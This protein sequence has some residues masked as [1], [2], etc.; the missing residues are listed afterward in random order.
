MSD[1]PINSLDNSEWDF[2]EIPEE[3]RWIAEIYEYSRENP[4][5]VSS[6]S[7]WL[8][9]DAYYID[10]W[11][12]DQFDGPLHEECVNLGMTVRKA[13]SQ[14]ATHSQEKVNEGS[15]YDWT[16]EDLVDVLN[17]PLDEHRLIKITEVLIEWPS[18]FVI[19]R[20]NE[21]VQAAISRLLDVKSL[22]R[23]DDDR[24]DRCVWVLP[25]DEELMAWPFVVAPEIKKFHIAIDCH[26]SKS[27]IRKDL[28][29]ILD[30]LENKTA[31]SPT[32][33]PRP[34]TLLKQ[35]AAFRLVSRGFKT[36]TKPTLMEIR[37][38]LSV[39][40]PDLGLDE[41][42]C[43][44]DDVFPNYAPNSMHAAF[45]KAQDRIKAYNL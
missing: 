40:F 11:V 45:L 43:N 12:E 21:F 14:L 30:C 2:R 7:E 1:E 5:V 33:P 34:T 41:E 24:Y 29:R 28:S 26:R 32:D 3:E 6:F 22:N 31:G 23:N 39:N 15:G 10:N 4:K 9:S 35:L 13:I 17:S 44:V 19:A 20:K 18:P 38:R 42:N 37:H 8:D 25:N 36:L 27:E 16:I